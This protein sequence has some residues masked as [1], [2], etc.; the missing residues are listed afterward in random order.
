MAD[1]KEASRPRV[2][3]I[4]PVKSKTYRTEMWKGIKEVFACE[5]CGANRDDQDAMIE[6]VLLHYPKARQ[7]E[8]LNEMLKEKK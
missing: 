3:V 1:K 2:M 6:H 5:F 8:L 4:E 7:E